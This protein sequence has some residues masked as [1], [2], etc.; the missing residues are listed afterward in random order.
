MFE[1]LNAAVDPVAHSRERETLSYANADLLQR[2]LD[3]TPQQV[4]NM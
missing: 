2:F 3:A 4:K 1:T